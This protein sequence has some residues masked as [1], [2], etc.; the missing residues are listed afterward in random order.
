MFISPFRGI[1]IYIINSHNGGVCSKNIILCD[2]VYSVAGRRTDV[3]FSFAHV[4]AVS[5]V[6]FGRNQHTWAMTCSNRFFVVVVIV[7]VVAVGRRS[8]LG[9][10]GDSFL[11]YYVVYTIRAHIYSKANPFL[12]A[13]WRCAWK[14]C[15]LHASISARRYLFERAVLHAATGHQ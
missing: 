10:R 6:S 14:L 12:F 9:A 8:G 7:A 13:S 1:H 4:L 15:S 2:P 11:I 3:C 5:S